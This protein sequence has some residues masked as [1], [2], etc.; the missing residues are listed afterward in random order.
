MGFTSRGFRRGLVRGPVRKTS[1]TFGSHTA[2]PLSRQLHKSPRI[3]LNVQHRRAGLNH[4]YRCVNDVLRLQLP[5]RLGIY[6]EARQPRT[7]NSSTLGRVP[8]V[9]PVRTDR[10][11]ILVIQP[12]VPIFLSNRHLHCRRTN[13]KRGGTRYPNTERPGIPVRGG[14]EA[15]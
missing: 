7:L 12:P 1:W 14:R 3:E 6:I 9:H 15:L 5:H 13:R 2:W 11:E 4:L 8:R 10:K